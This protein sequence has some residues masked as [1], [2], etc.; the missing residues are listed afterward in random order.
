MCEMPTGRAVSIAGSGT[1]GVGT[2]L[3]TL[4]V[5]LARMPGS[6]PGN[7]EAVAHGDAAGAA[8]LLGER[9]A[10]HSGDLVSAPPQ[11]GATEFLDL[12]RTRLL[13]A[14]VRW[15][16]PVVLSFNDVPFEVLDAAFAG[17]RCRSGAAPCSTRP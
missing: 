17:S 10:V 8:A 14:G 5:P 16:V 7:E 9:P 11:L 2:K 6:V 13:A 12:D 3:F 4:N 1:R 15:A